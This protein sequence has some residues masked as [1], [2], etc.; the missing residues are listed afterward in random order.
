VLSLRTVNLL[1]RAYDAPFEPPSTVGDVIGLHARRQLAEIPGL[2]RRRLSEIEAAIVFAGL[3]LTVYSSAPRA[4]KGPPRDRDS[5]LRDRFP[6]AAVSQGSRRMTGGSLPAVMACGPAGAGS[7]AADGPARSLRAYQAAAVEALVAELTGGGRAQAHMACGTGKTLVAASVAARLAAGGV[8]VVLAPSIALVAQVLREWNAGCPVD[9]ALAVCSDQ[10]AGRGGVARRDLAAPVSTDPEFIAKWVAGTAGR[11]LVAGTYDSAGRVAEGLRLAGQEAE[12]AVCDEAHHLAGAA[13]KFTAA[14]VRP[15]FLPSRRFLFLTATPKIVTGAGRDGELAVASMD[16]QELFGRRVF[17]YPAG[18][19]IADGWLKEYRLVVAAVSDADTAALLEERGEM[20]G[21]GG[22]PL[23][24]AAAQAALAMAVAELGLRRCVAFVPT[25]AEARLFARTLAGTL[26]MLPEER[27]PR[28][29]VSAGFVH[30]RMNSAQREIA[31]GALRRPPEGGWS[32]VANARC[33]TEGIDIPDIDSVLFAA[34]KDSITDIIQAAGRPLRLSAE[35]GTAAIIVPAVLPGDDD[36]AQDAGVGRWENVVR[37]VRALSAHDDRLAASMA[38]ARAARPAGLRTGGAEPALPPAIDVQAP[39]GTAARVLD[40]LRVRIIDGTASQWWEWHALLREYRLEHGHADVPGGYQAPGGGELGNWLS[41]QKVGHADGALPAERAA[42]LEELGVTW[43]AGEA[44][45]QRGL[46]HATAYRAAHGH[47]NVPHGQAGSDGFRLYP[48]LAAARARLA[49][50]IL[51]PGRASQLRALDFTGQ[52]N[53]QAAFQR[54][55]DALDAYIAAN[56]HAAVPISY[57]TP[58]GYR[59]GNWISS[60]RSPQ[61]K[62]TAAARGALGERG[63]IWDTRAAGFAEGLDHLDAYITA[64]GQARPPGSY[65]AP[66]GYPLGRWLIRQRVRH[67]HPGNGL[68]ALSAAEAAALT[69]RGIS[70]DH[71]INP[72]GERKPE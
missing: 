4:R 55:L 50:G 1:A 24:M 18:K 64:H 23:R 15:G 43:S 26:A 68:R 9:R 28:G 46:E 59:L 5:R 62:L 49:A 47:L 65:T 72:D 8:T 63:M 7:G 22:A 34:P 69:A 20:A 30:G 14:A 70:L 41:R 19:A 71:R 27:R 36:P 2:G 57:V 52:T 35:A 37:V 53:T 66:D 25:V 45:W 39:P 54:G 48:W 21:E 38:A 58:D 31:L 10:T 61:A 44:S 40:A 11:A 29:P 60:K 3:D 42:A 6:A 67:G 56:G 13:G 33:L 17:S 32:V 51:D 12:L 16:N